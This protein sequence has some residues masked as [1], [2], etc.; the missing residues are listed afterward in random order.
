M[1]HVITKDDL[2]GLMCL[3]IYDDIR[4]PQ[5]DKSATKPQRPEPS[6]G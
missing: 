3:D 4:R 6:I 5:Y 2:E 1:N